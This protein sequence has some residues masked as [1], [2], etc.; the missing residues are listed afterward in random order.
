[1]GP[2]PVYL[3]IA[4]EKVKNQNVKRKTTKLTNEK[5]GEYLCNSVDRKAFLKKTNST[6]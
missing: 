5:A 2:P 1:M 4:C 3:Y 6:T